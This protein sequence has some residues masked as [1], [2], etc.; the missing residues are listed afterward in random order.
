MHSPLGNVDAKELSGF[1]SLGSSVE[2]LESLENHDGVVS[3]INDILDPAPPNAVEKERAIG[4]TELDC[5]VAYLVGS[6]EIASED[7][8][9]LVEG[10]IDDIS[11]GASRLTY[12][13]QFM[14]A[15]AVSL[16]GALHNVEA[17]SQASLAAETNVALDRLHFLD[18]VRRN[19]EAA[20]E[21]LCEAEN[22]GTL[23]SDVTLLL[24]E[25]NY[26]KAAER[27]SE[28]SKSMS[29]F[30]NTPEYE[31]RR[32]LM[33]SLQNQLEAA[34][35]S[36]LVSAVT[37]QDV[38]VCRSY[39]AIFSNIQ[40]ETEFRNYYYGSRRRPLVEMWQG[41]RLH[42]H[43]GASGPEP[44]MQTFSTFLSSFYS[45]FLSLL[46]TECT[47]VSAVFPDPQPTLS[48][49]I[50]ST[51]S[52]LQPTFSQRLTEISM[53]HGASTLRELILA[54]R[55]TE[56]LA[57]AVEKIFEK[58]RYT[59]MLAPVPNTDPNAVSQPRAHIRRRSSARMSMSMTRR[60]SIHHTSTNSAGL[61]SN[62]STS[63]PL[64]W[65]HELFLPFAEFQADYDILERRLLDDV[66]KGVLRTVP[67]TRG[68]RARVLRERAVDV[69][70]AAEDA[71]GRCLAFT[72]G[73]GAACLVQA[74][75]RTISAFAEASRTEVTTRKG[76]S[77][78]NTSAG[79][80]SS[81]EDLSDLDYTAEDWA[82]I[83]S[84][85]HLLEAVRALLDRTIVYEGKFRAGLVQISATLRAVRRD[86]GSPPN[87]TTRSAIQLLMQSTLNSAALHSLLN[88]V[89][90]EISQPP[91]SSRGDTF[92][93]RTPPSPGPFQ[94]FFMPALPQNPS[95][96]HLL[97]EARTAISMLA[98]ACQ[99][100]LLDTLL[101][102]LRA[103]LSAY[104][105]LP[106]WSSA[107]AAKSSSVMADGATS[108]VRVPAFSRS[109]STTMQ[110][111]AEGLLTLPRLLEVHAGDGALAF[112]LRTLPHVSSALLRALAEPSHEN[113]VV[114][115]GVGMQHTRCAPSLA[116]KPGQA[117]AQAQMQMQ[118]QQAQ[119]QSE[120]AS[121]AL[122]DLHL[123][124]SSVTAAWLVSLGCTLLAALTSS[125]LPRIPKLSP[126]GAAQLAEDLGYLGN[127]VLAL[128]VEW[129]ALGA[130]KQWTEMGEEEGWRRVRE[131]AWV[132]ES[133]KDEGSE[134][135]NGAEGG[136]EWERAS[137][138]VGRIVA[139]L[140]G[141]TL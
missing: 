68:D 38:A 136:E 138:E 141:W 19:M 126:A 10:I 131:G 128:N 127:V 67:R 27:L 99:V 137:E 74:V 16:Q 44:A 112:S 105:S 4:L 9:A 89:D 32:T 33:V 54:Y 23:E 108:A 1:P 117:Q 59:A 57:I 60:M 113:A 86:P 130:W 121:E 75:D 61:P 20:R 36:A 129:H 71:M 95:T 47:F 110:R 37:S 140:R 24:A 66:L 78:G 104:A 21:V 63:F 122:D 98:R 46:Q 80:P 102:P 93:V 124:P 2:L 48:T 118:A 103:H 58:V 97:T 8:S 51:L 35:S 30:E 50:T 26:E 92:L 133:E 55:A 77:S 82:D 53:Y 5:R 17:K 125:V 28:A 76:T 3:W 56:E 100:A 115:S 90:P 132:L 119:D 31:I 18:T 22:W 106:V 87:G 64:E 139:R 52:A 83:Q 85:L 41:A 39:F 40:R 73:Y 135:R 111:V 12:D 70:E 43:E 81:C 134:E 65:D 69:F 109:P 120:G 42:G 49:L 45:S 11:R 94:S 96:A 107:D 91:P 114:S 14:R 15:G 72:H 88:S 79:A 34:L 7:T 62:P 123:P 101:A 116:L 29:V 6:L 84:T 25:K 13:L